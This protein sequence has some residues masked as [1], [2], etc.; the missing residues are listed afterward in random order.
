MWSNVCQPKELNER[1]C[2][3]IEEKRRRQ[4]S[5]VVRR[6]AELT[7]SHGENK[8]VKWNSQRWQRSADFCQKNAAMLVMGKIWEENEESD[9]FIWRPPWISLWN[10]MN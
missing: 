9:T 5:I 3:N 10:M 4:E 2:G 6:R 1:R 7:L 8:K